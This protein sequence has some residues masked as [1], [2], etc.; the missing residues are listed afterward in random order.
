M[1]LFLGTLAFAIWNTEQHADGALVYS[2][3]DAY[4][5]MAMAKNLARHGVWGSTPYHFSSSSS[6][7]LWTALLGLAY[8]VAG[9]RDITPMI[10]NALFGLLTLAVADRYLARWRAP[11]GLRAAALAGITLGAPLAGLALLGMEH[12]LHLLL[13]VWFAGAAI[14][15]LSEE[16][17]SR[18]IAW[19]CGLGALLVTSRYEGLFLIAVVSACFALKGL[20]ARGLVI[21]VVS[22]L[23]TV[24]F[25]AISILNG[26]LFFPNSLLIK[27][28]GENVSMVT[29]L[30]KPIG[31]VDLAFLTEHDEL[32]ILVLLGLAGAIM[33][34]RD[35]RAFW[36][37][38]VLAPLFLALMILLH[39]HYTFTTMFWEYRYAAYLTAFGVFAAAV[40]LT[41]YWNDD[42]NTG[43]ISG[44]VSFAS[45]AALIWLVTDVSKGLSSAQEVWLA[46]NT[47]AE[48]VNAAKFV[49]QY[50]PSATVVVNDIGAVTYYTDARVI[51]MFGLGDIEPVTIR[52]RQGGEY[53]VADVQSW[54]A[55]LHPSIAV[56]QVGWSFVVPRIPDQWVKVGDLELPSDGE[57][58]GFFALDRSE[59]RPL[60]SHLEAFY[61]PLAP[62]GYR[63]KLSDPD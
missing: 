60:R 51:D 55:P 40:L 31:Q 52:R 62:K 17:H 8:F 9:V 49:R 33:Q 1:G 54:I 42:L 16:S 20:W 34:W 19:L 10:L 61:G 43:P 53:N 2:L 38:Q 3:D 6:S 27:A 5:H 30:F 57:H 50:Y 63:L 11:A 13:T 45:L 59:E 39:G 15:A 46:T 29:A 22:V 35:R 37:P 26:W 32:F 4:I 28:G 41:D 24:L 48:H 56:L 47:N 44:I 14:E 58:M 12:I 36:R 25:G 18:R 23:P 7:L 21:G